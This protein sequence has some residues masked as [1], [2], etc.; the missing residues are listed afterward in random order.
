VEALG[1]EEE[2]IGRLIEESRDG[3]VGGRDGGST[4]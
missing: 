3:G 4:K 2:V 1:I